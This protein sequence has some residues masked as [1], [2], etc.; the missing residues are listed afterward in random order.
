[1]IRTIRIEGFKSLATLSLELGRVNCFIGANGVGK[2]NILEAI[3]VLGAAANGTV[4]DESLR[5]RGVRPGLPR[6]YKS[7]FEAGRVPPHIALAAE[8]EEVEMYRVSLLNP[9]ENPQPAWTFKTEY[10]TDG[11]TDIVSEGVR[12][13][14]RINPAAGL[15]ALKVVDLETESPALRLM[16]ALQGYSIYTPDTFTL[17]GLIADQQSREP[18]GLSGGQLAD[19]FA[20]LRKNGLSKDEDLLESVVEL[21]DWVEDIQT[22]TAAGSLLSP[23][24]PRSKTVLK[25]T[26]RFMK[27]GRNTLTSHDA[28]EG[29]LYVLFC[30]VLCLSPN[31]PRLLAIDNLDQALNPRL[32]ARLTAKLGPWLSHGGQQRQMMFT[33]HNPAVLDGLDLEDD[34]I[35]LFAVDRDSDGHT[36]V[37]RITLTENLLKLNKDYPLSR[38]WLMGHLGAVPNV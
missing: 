13:S 28:S 12:S 5:R 8:G 10:L 16:Q 9:L 22:T 35:R 36:V 17:R 1:M 32:V 21:I 14:K 34:E 23:S 27:K 4:D 2:S 6:L 20:A 25:F 26:D 33:A 15:A 24:V 37:N 31:A 18:V 7:S 30:A 3:G 19:A 11:I 38:L 29:A